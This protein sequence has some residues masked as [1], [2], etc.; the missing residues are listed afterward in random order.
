M[1][2]LRIPQFLLLF[3]IVVS[4]PCFASIQ[5]MKDSVAILLKQNLN[6]TKELEKL[7]YYITQI[8]IDDKIND[9]TINQTLQ[10]V[11]RARQSENDLLLAD[12]LINLVRAYLNQYESSKSLENALEA[13]SLYE[14][15]N[16]KLKVAYTNMQLG[17]IYYTQ[18]NYLKS[19][20]Y[21]QQ[22]IPMYE[23][24]NDTL[25]SSTLYYLCGINYT[26]LQQFESAKIN[27]QKALALKQKLNNTQ[28][29]AEC[30]AGLSEL[31]LVQ[32]Q[33]DSALKY[34]IESIKLS[35]DYGSMYGVAKATLLK[36]KALNMKNAMSEAF[37]NAFAALEISKQLSA[38]ELIVD[39]NEILYQL[40]YKKEN[41]KD[42]YK[43]LY[44][45]MMMR[46]SIF[47]EKTS[48]N[49][50]RLETDYIIEKKQTEILLL[51]NQNKNRAILLKATIIIGILSLLLSALF[52]NRFQIKQK[53]NKELEKAYQDL[54]KTQQQLIQQEKLA[55]LGQL[56]AGIA[57]EIK[58]PLNFVNNFSLISNDLIKEYKDSKDEQTKSEIINDL[59][60]NISKINEHGKRA[61]SI[62][63]KM[64]EHSRADIGQKQMTDINR[65]CREDTSLAYK[66]ILMGN[67]GFQ[68]ETQIETDDKLPMV[69]VVSQ[70]I[71]RVLLNIVN[72]CFYAMLE[73]RKTE[74]EYLPKLL[75]KTGLEGKFIS[76][77][78]RD[79][80]NGIKPE[81]TEKIFQPFFTTK[82]PGEG[83]GLGLSISYDIVKA[84]GGNIIAG[85]HTSGGAE[86]KIT[87]P[88]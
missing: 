76:I 75:I 57:H 10:I 25:R 24:F 30:N 65:L 2:K 61:N 4:L 86:F 41:H 40:N 77:I 56:T 33:P 47:N 69:F 81:I 23:Q 7:N 82:P 62:V 1:Y 31:S 49:F 22:A 21:Y 78:I 19:L 48:R 18:K 68:C 54:E 37:E 14:K 52:Y 27:L 84:H 35:H 28:G 44:D 39:A 20:E 87:L 26:R 32:N 58:N 51:E 8:W 64:L 74:P 79:N 3:F 42:A 80:G 16:E 13:K 85:N 5:N 83:T 50:S 71:S 36:S 17:V 12:A 67:P 6:S 72:N 43:Y 55:S 9:T 46:D 53:A 29:L 38:K 15:H 73:K 63:T 59:E 45:Y 60:V 70:E 34:S 11:E 88:I 66:A